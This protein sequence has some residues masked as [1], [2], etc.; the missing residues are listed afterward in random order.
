MCILFYILWW[1]EVAGDVLGV[2][3]LWRYGV[4]EL[5]SQLFKTMY[6]SFI[7]HEVTWKI[8]PGDQICKHVDGIT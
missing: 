5:W 8:G 3:E 6:P 4:L 1:G 2:M 7:N